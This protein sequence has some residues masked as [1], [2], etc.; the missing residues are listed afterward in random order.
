MRCS[1]ERARL[2]PV[3]DDRVRGDG[4]DARVDD[5]EA[6]LGIFD[7]R[8]LATAALDHEQAAIDL[9]PPVHPRGILL[10]DEAALGEA[11]PV[12][13]GRI[14]FEPEHVAELRAAFADAEAEPVLEPADCRLG[15]GREPAPAER[16]KPRIGDTLV[17]S[18]DQW[19][20][21]EASRS[22]RIGRRR[23]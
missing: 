16:G 1:T 12:Q 20:A 18:F 23:R 7:A 2:Q 21:S 10:A 14:A 5:G 17:P 13:L 11:D 19:T 6:E 4:V 3:G 8:A 22:I 15:R 9:L